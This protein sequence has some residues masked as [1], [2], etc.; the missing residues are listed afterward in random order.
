ME[1]PYICE[2]SRPVHTYSGPRGKDTK[3]ALIDKKKFRM[4][5]IS[6]ATHSIYNIIGL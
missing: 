3:R 5:Y 1:S 4:Y 2:R 6:K